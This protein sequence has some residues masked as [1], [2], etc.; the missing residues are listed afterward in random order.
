MTQERSGTAAAEPLHPSRLALLNE[1]ASTVNFNDPVREWRRLFAEFWGTFL[2]VLFA[3]GLAMAAETDPARTSHEAA[4]IAP[5]IVVMVVIY[6]AGSV[7]GA[8]LNPAVT[9]AFALRGNFPWRRTAGYILAQSAGG[10][11]AAVLLSALLGAGGMFGA[12]LPGS[13]VSDAKAF[14][15]EAVLTAA[16]VNVI[17]ATAS[18]ARNVGA[19][20][21]IAVGG[22]IAVAGLWGGPISGGSM[23]P[24]RSLAVDIV[25]GQLGQSW[26]YVA[27]PVVG[28]LVGVGFEWILKSG[29]SRAG[30]AAAQGEA[31]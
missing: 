19:N 26:I 17:L 7:S 4:A 11:L 23:N 9:L 25:R 12:T 10:L 24:V 21:A 28:A 16:L 5:G 22:F 20:A 3:A 31:P 30:S 15:V 6:L 1:I 13:G 14:V 2:L 27:G 18:G 8:H 29:P